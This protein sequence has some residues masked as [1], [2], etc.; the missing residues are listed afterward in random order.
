MRASDL[1][2][3][4]QKYNLDHNPNAL[5]KEA[6]SHDMGDN[7]K[8]QLSNTIFDRMA[9]LMN[10]TYKY[11]H[12]FTAETDG[13]E[14][15]T[16]QILGENRYFTMPKYLYLLGHDLIDP[17]QPEKTLAYVEIANTYGIQAVKDV[18]TLL[19]DKK[20]PLETVLETYVIDL[21]RTL[22]RNTSPVL[23][24][25]SERAREVDRIRIEEYLQDHPDVQQRYNTLVNEKTEP[26]FSAPG[27]AHPAEIFSTPSSHDSIKKT[28]SIPSFFPAQEDSLPLHSNDLNAPSP[29][30]KV[31]NAH[32]G[33]RVMPN[34]IIQKL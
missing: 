5:F 27:A 34:L 29:S 13:L 25:I 12:G 23:M 31:T 10:D 20:I 6:T 32:V 9:Q 8:W 19:E 30:T 17:S 18:R 24:A 2:D 22:N 28:V 3:L 1:L 26:A 16:H 11:K 15:L 4:Y 21:Q 14:Q 33:Q 7:N